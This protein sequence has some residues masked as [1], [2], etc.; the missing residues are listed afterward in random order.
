MQ[1]TAGD[2]ESRHGSNSPTDSVNDAFFEIDDEDEQAF[3]LIYEYDRVA[4]QCFE[5]LMWIDKELAKE[6]KKKIAKDPKNPEQIRDQLKEKYEKNVSPYDSPSL[7]R[8]LH[9][10]REIGAK[11]EYE[12]KRIVEVLGEHVDVE[13]V[14][15]KLK[16]KYAAS[17]QVSEPPPLEDNQAIL[18]AK[19]GAR[20]KEELSEEGVSRWD[21]AWVWMVA[22]TIV[23]LAF[24]LTE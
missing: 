24:T 3:Q 17:E 13:H 15:N 23:G 9:E 4:H 1:T 12:F 16:E 8:A 20:T 21:F 7:N 11:A 18:T 14:I 22:I 2:L 19:D 10:A 5:D 6:F